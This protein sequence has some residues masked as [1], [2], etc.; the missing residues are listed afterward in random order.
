MLL[1]AYNIKIKV[2]YMQIILKTTYTEK[3]WMS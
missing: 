3:G 2:L 1:W